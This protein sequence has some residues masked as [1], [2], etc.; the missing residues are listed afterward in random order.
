MSDALANGGDLSLPGDVWDLENRIAA[1]EATCT[2]GGVP[3][4]ANGVEIGTLVGIIHG[5]YFNFIND[6][7]YL[8]W[9]ANGVSNYRN[10][11]EGDILGITESLPGANNIL[12]FQTADCSGQAYLVPNTGSVGNLPANQGS[13]F[14]SP[15][16]GDLIDIY[17]LP[18]GTSPI[19]ITPDSYLDDEGCQTQGYPVGHNISKVWR[20]FPNAPQET[21]VYNTS[22]PAPITLGW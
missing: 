21:G 13:V 5:S 3:I 17:Y 8:I 6:Y 20:A 11:V 4:L 14:R 16:V 9:I 22:Y 15:W 19:S 18:Q 12:S 10:R 7:G 2:K 1:L